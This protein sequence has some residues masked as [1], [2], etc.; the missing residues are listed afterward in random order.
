MARRRVW[1]DAAGGGFI[2]KLLK[3]GDRVLIRTTDRWGGDLSRSVS[4]RWDNQV[5]NAADQGT[6][7]V[8]AA[9]RDPRGYAANRANQLQNSVP[10]GQR[11]RVTMGAGVG[12]DASGR[13]RVVVG[14]SEDGGYLR[15]GVRLDEGEELATGP[16]HAER[17]ILQYMEDNGI[18]PEY[19]GAG[20]PICDEP[21]SGASNGCAG[22]IAESGARAATPYRN[23]SRWGNVP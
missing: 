7:A 3:S 18:T 17:N 14:T 13:T 5:R 12:R 19:V 23:P 4:R 9:A 22:S 15:R 2:M 6:P 20:K 21:I 1:P 16:Y 11:G 10:A 8:R